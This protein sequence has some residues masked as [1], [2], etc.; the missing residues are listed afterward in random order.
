MTFSAPLG[1]IGSKLHAPA[2][3]AQFPLGPY[4]YTEQ[5]Y[6]ATGT[7]AGTM[8]GYPQSARFPALPFTT[9]II[10]RRPTNPGAAN[11][12]VLLEWMNASLQ[13]DTDV[14][15]IEGYREL[16]RAGFTYVGVSVQPT[17]VPLPAQ[18]PVRYGQIRIPPYG[19]N[20]DAVA[21]SQGGPSYGESIFGP[22]PTR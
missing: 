4:G 5:E 17:G 22:S 7:A 6:L 16:L 8:A 10:V 11:G 1:T 12:T 19:P 13:Q 2:E 15:W 21:P 14:D 18:D 3:T 20:A 9:R